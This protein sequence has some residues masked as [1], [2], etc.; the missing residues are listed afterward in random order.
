MISTVS[1]ESA[2]R[3][4]NLASLCGET[5]R[6]GGSVNDASHVGATARL[7]GAGRGGTRQVRDLRDGNL[8][9]A[10]ERRQEDSRAAPGKIMKPRP[11]SRGAPR[12]APCPARG[13]PALARHAPSRS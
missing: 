6:E 7:R 9:E 8:L 11:D 4:E 1:R 12:A 10:A 2:P 5:P 3:S 13:S